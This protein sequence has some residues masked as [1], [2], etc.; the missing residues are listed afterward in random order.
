M[1]KNEPKGA[2]PYTPPTE[3]IKEKYKHIFE[4]ENSLPPRFF[5]MLF[6]KFVSLIMIIISI[7]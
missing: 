2:F 5:K 3:E 1:N 7:P 4:I 6:D